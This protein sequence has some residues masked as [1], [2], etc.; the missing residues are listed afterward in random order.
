MTDFLEA[1]LQQRRSA[2]TFRSLQAQQGLI[3]LTSND[4]FG[5]ARDTESSPSSST[6]STGSRLLTGNHPFYERLEERL[7]KFHRAESC[8]IFNSGYDANLGLISALGTEEVTFL[9]DLEIHASMIDGLRLSRAK[10]MPFRHNDL[11]SLERRLKSVSLP[12][13]VLVESIYSISGTFAPLLEIASVCASY[14]AELIVDEAHATGVRGDKGEGRVCELNLSTQTFARVH[15]FSKALGAHGAC[16][17][18][19]QAL[20][21][22]LLNFSRPLIYSTA[23]PLPS[24][25]LIAARYEKMEKEAK[26]HQGRLRQLAEHLTQCLGQNRGEGP[27]FPFIFPGAANVR[28]KSQHLREAGFDVRAIVAPTAPRGKEALRLVLHSFNRE[29]EITQIMEILQCA[30]LS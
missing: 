18:G 15:T 24:F 21:N 1:K 25:Y 8:L 14:G 6:G 22:Y 13:F 30:P 29:E 10:K 19:S 4:Y 17:V 12:A 5:L 28:A 26:M 11:E 7:A 23:M 3:D 16:V 20:K 9:Y 2:G 27:I